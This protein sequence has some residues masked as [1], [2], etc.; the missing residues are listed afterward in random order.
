MADLLPNGRVLSLVIGFVLLGAVIINGFLT[1]Q[2]FDRVTA[3]AVAGRVA[4]VKELSEQTSREHREMRETMERLICVNRLPDDRKMDAINQG[5][6]VCT[7]VNALE[8]VRRQNDS[9][10]S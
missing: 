6:D 7:Y 10:P 9:P 3:E 1:R 2:A 5:G 8:R 4:A